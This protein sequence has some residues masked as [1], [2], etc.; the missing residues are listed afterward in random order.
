MSRKKLL[1][2]QR[3]FHEISS[4]NSWKNWIPSSKVTQKYMYLFY[5]GAEKDKFSPQILCLEKVHCLSDFA[6]SLGHH[7]MYRLWNQ[8]KRQLAG[9]V[10]LESP[11]NLQASHQCTT[12]IQCTNLQS[13]S[14]EIHW[15]YPSWHFGRIRTSRN[16]K[17]RQVVPLKYTID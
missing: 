4:N 17:L 12:E 9:K 14:Q 3:K 6:N 16:L 10:E 1:Q 5:E 15:W 13:H 7:Y 2:C 11:S 8:D